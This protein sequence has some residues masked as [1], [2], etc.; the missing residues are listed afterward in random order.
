MRGLRLMFNLK[1][2]Q[3]CIR[4]SSEPVV[5]INDLA[6]VSKILTGTLSELL[7]PIVTGGDMVVFYCVF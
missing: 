2:G 3:H 1:H 4:Q 5:T 6:N 7:E